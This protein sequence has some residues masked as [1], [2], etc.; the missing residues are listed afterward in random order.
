MK[1]RRPASPLV[2]RRRNNYATMLKVGALVIFVQFVIV[3]YAA[4]QFLNKQE[5][6]QLPRSVSVLQERLLEA[7][8]LTAEREMQLKRM[9]SEYLGNAQFLLRKLSRTSLEVNRQVNL[10]KKKPQPAAKTFVT[11]CMQSSL[12]NKRDECPQSSLSLLTYNIWGAQ[13]HWR[14]RQTVM[15]VTSLPGPAPFS[16]LGGGSQTNLPPGCR[17]LCMA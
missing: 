6:V 14:E 17:C 2:R 9:Q 15:Q 5:P 4:I 8:A 13:K 16:A 11:R 12:K 1:P 10:R 7:E 3:T